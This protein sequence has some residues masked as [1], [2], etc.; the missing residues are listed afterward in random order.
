MG[1]I[2]TEVGISRKVKKSRSFLKK[3]GLVE[4]C[5]TF[6][7]QMLRVQTRLFFVRK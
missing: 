5:N 7:V 1:K 4:N 3:S 6:K 2:S